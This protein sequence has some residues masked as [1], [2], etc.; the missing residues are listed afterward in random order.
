MI[1]R[2]FKEKKYNLKQVVTA[3]IGFNRGGAL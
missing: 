1:F 3:C 2:R